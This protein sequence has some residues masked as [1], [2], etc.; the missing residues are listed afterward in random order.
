MVDIVI[1]LIFVFG[2]FTGLRRGFIL[3]L[4]HVAGFIIAFIVAYMYYAEFALKLKLWIPYPTIHE[5]ATFKMFFD[6][7][8]LEE[9]YYRAIAF[10]IIFFAVKIVLH[11][12]GS[13]LD[14]VAKFPIIKQLNVWAGGILGFL[15]VY[16]I[17]FI[18]LYIGALIPIE[19]IQ[20]AIDKSFLADAMI[21]NTPILSNQMKQWWL[22]YV[23]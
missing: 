6:G 15:E 16:F 13:A 18:V 11:I 7:M 2:F 23:S 5:N 8:N 19:F 21:K 1:L 22:N 10:A 9:A 17:V 12:I 3:Q 14:F 4:I 20:H